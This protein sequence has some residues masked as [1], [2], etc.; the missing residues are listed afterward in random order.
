MPARKAPKA[1]LAAVPAA[2][3]APT[4][5]KAAPATPPKKRGRPRINPIPEPKPVRWWTPSFRAKRGA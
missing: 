5:Q 1:S 3:P 2:E 4:R